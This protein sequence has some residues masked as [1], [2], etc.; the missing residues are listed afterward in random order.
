MGIALELLW[1]P[2]TDC[3]H[4]LLHACHVVTDGTPT[5]SLRKQGKPWIVT[6]KSAAGALVLPRRARVPVET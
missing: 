6:T 1:A 3:P 5:F 2:G 4:L